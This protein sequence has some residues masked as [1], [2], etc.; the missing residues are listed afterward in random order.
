ML[1]R[2]FHP[3]IRELKKQRIYRI[4]T[5]RDY[6][7]LEPIVNR[8]GGNIKMDPIVEQ[9]DRMGQFYATYAVPSLRRPSAQKLVTQQH[10]LPLNVLIQ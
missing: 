6:S 4:N 5:N 8:P 10:L 2:R 7:A 9:W 1:G 3:R